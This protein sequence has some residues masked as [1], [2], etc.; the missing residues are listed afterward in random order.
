MQRRRKFWQKTQSLNLNA[1]LTTLKEEEEEEEL[2]KLSAISEPQ[3]GSRA[4]ERTDSLVVFSSFFLLFLFDCL[5]ALQNSL[6]ILPKEISELSIC[7]S[8]SKTH[9]HQ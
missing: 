1:N 8:R 6:A 2:P 3:F 7:T 4:A 5:S 9:T